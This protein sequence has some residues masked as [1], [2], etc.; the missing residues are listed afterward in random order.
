MCFC[1]SDFQR[2]I[3]YTQEDPVRQ[4]IPVALKG[5]FWIGIPCIFEATVLDDRLSQ[6][7]YDE[8]LL[9]HV[10]NNIQSTI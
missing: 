6:M 7:P 4:G 5:C 10:G 8:C 9:S 3:L 2:N 1:L